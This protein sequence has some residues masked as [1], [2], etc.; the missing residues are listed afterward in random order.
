LDVKEFSELPT[1]QTVSLRESI[2]KVG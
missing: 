1:Q 2:L